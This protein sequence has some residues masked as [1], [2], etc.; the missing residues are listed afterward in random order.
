MERDALVKPER[1]PA[2]QRSL[3]GLHWAYQELIQWGLPLAGVCT[4][5]QLE[6]NGLV[7]GN[8]DHEEQGEGCVGG[9]C[10]FFA[11]SPC[12]SCPC[13]RAAHDS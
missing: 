1:V 5:A 3:G 9:G 12:A 2:V 4:V 7:L 10:A 8:I 6:R 11:S 13:A